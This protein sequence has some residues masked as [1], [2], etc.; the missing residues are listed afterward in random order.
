MGKGE[1]VARKIFG[2]IAPGTQEKEPN[3]NLFS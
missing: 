1:K 3:T 2:E